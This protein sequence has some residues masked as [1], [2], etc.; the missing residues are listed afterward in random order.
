MK[1]AK[2]EKSAKVLNV[3]KEGVWWLLMVVWTYKKCKSGKHAKL[4]KSTNH[5]KRA[6]V[7]LVQN[8]LH[9]RTIKRQILDYAF[10]YFF[11]F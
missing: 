5:A 4:A 1:R 8:V 6:K 2:S 11:I 9:I 3:Q 10:F 7:Q